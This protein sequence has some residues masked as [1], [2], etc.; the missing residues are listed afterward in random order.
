[1]QRWRDAKCG[2]GDG[3]WRYGR[4]AE[5][6][7]ATHGFAVDLVAAHDIV[8]SQHAHPKGE[9][10]L[11]IPLDRNAGFD[12]SAAGWKVYPPAWHHAPAVS[13]GRVLVLC[14]TPDGA[15]A[16]PGMP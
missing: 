10:V 4:V 11:V 8:F 7:P 15:M 3:D 1:M 2:Q 14:F 12:G 16:G 9:V 5:A 13:G 6:S